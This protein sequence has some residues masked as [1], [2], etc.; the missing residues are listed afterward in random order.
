M[1]DED[2]FKCPLLQGLDA[3][4]RAE[5]LGLLNDSNLRRRLE[6]CLGRIKAAEPVQIAQSKASEPESFDRKV[7]EW[8]PKLPIWNRSSKE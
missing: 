6:D 5:L 8:N 7:H 1:K 4:H 2:L 3:M